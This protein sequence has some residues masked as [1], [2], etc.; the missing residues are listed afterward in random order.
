MYRGMTLEFGQNEQDYLPQPN[1]G[2]YFL[3]KKHFAQNKNKFITEN[4]LETHLQQQLRTKIYKQ[5][6]L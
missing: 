5:Q 3:K 4:F 2:D 1:L 6:F